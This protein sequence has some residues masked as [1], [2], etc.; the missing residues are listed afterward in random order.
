MASRKETAEFEQGVSELRKDLAGGSFHGVYIFYGEEAYLV[1]SYKKQIIDK[2]LKPGDTMNL[3]VF[4]DRWEEE[5]FISAASTIPFISDYRVVVLEN[6]GILS[7]SSD[8]VSAF[9]KEKP[10]STIVIVT[11]VVTRDSSGRPKSVMDRRKGIYKAFKPHALEINCIRQTPTVLVRW[12]RGLAK[13]EKKAMS[14]QAAVRFVDR[15]GIDMTL[16]S[17]EMEKLFSYTMGRDSITVE[18]VD[19]ITGGVPSDRIFEFVDAVAVGD[20][21]KTMA[22]YS[23]LMTLGTGSGRIVAMLIRHFNLLLNATDLKRRGLPV[24]S[25]AK[26]MGVYQSFAGNYLN[27]AA[28]FKRKELVGILESFA[29]MQHQSRTGL[30]SADIGLEM[31][32]AGICER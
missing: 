8:P 7:A 11:E 17:N 12:V 29:Q 25:I 3:T 5:S 15:A 28:K 2:V 18:D 4:T 6:T 9:L 14:E 21:K 26:E 27:Q 23:D 30:I 32:I 19:A 24:A 10:E 31:L 20:T 13:G 16:I 1:S 22:L